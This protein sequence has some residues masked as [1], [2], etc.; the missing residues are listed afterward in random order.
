MIS[1]YRSQFD[2]KSYIYKDL[3]ES[4]DKHYRFNSSYNKIIT[5]NDINNF[6]LKVSGNTL[7]DL[8]SEDQGKFGH[9]LNIQY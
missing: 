1:V 8:L 3:Q 4:L 6:N 9:D 5:I 7:I 2:K